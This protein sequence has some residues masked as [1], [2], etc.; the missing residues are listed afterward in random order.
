VVE[1][2]H[3]GIVSQEIFNQV[4]KLMDG[5]TRNVGATKNPHLFSGILFC[6]NCGCRMQHHG[7]NS[8]TDEYFSC[9]KYRSYGKE[10]C[11]SHHI[12]IGALTDV[13]LKDI[14]KNIRL[15]QEDENRAIKRIIKIKCADGEKQIST[16]RRDLE[17]Q[18][19]RLSEISNKIKKV[20]EDNIS[21][22]I[23]DDLFND[24]VRDY[25][26]E[27]S[28]L[29]ESIKSLEEKIHNIEEN[30][31][32]V[33]HFSELLREYADITELNRATLLALVD[34]VSIEEPPDSYGKDRPRQ[35]VHIYY[36]FVGEI[37][38]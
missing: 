22:R 6:E 24:L 21:G 29:Q 34:K 4:Q 10:G 18:K 7:R 8:H 9:G 33:T 28:A 36:K 15:F 5:R 2:V 25:Q 32:D 14:Q 30:R 38:L 17:K 20:Y 13:V 19:K 26:S 35:T 16:A 11:S 1:G 27:K 23:P 3:E 12:K 31:V 37:I